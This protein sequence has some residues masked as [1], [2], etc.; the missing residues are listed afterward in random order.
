MTPTPP[1]DRVRSIRQRLRDGAR[2]RN[3]DFQYV[4]DRFAVERMLYR[5]SQSPYQQQFL[6]KGAMLFAIWFDVPHRPT[7]DAD[8]L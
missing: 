6:L 1:A 8:F 4:L 2:A 5:L 7:R 3:E